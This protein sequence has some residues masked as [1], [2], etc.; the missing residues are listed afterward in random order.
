MATICDSFPKEYEVRVR[1]KYF[2][3]YTSSNNWIQIKIENLTI[4][5][6]L[7]NGELHFCLT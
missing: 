2:Y 1:E 4:K 5:T 3:C 7:R 6:D